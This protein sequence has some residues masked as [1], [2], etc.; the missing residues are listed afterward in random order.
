MENQ[1]T[2][3]EIEI[4]LLEIFTI[5]LSR[6]ALIMGAGIFTALIGLCIS[7]FI[8]TPVYESTTKIYILNKTESATVI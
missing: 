6:I 2:S 4:D 7:S 8:L 5:L 1:R 3:D